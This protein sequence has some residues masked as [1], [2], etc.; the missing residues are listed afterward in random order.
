MR[1]ERFCP[2]CRGALAAD[3]SDC[4]H[5]ARTLTTDSMTAQLGRTPIASATPLDEGPTELPRA[6]AERYAVQ[7]VLGRGG[8]GVV[9]RAR[10]LRLGRE[11]ALK[12]LRETTP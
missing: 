10:D 4:P 5:C 8:I 11:V 1:T 3:A 2:A 12:L 7:G 9:F 6:L